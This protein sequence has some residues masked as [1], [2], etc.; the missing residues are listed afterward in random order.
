VDKNKE[1]LTAYDD[2]A[3]AIFRHCY[4][5]VLD[6]EK[7]KDLV[8]DSFIRLWKYI[9]RGEDVKN[10]KALVYKIANNLI[11]DESRKK[12]AVS[13]ELLAEKG[14]DP[15]FDYMPKLVSELDSRFIAGVLPRLEPK[16]REAVT[17][18]YVDDFSVQEIAEMTNE[19]EN[20]VSVRIH[21]GLKQL[22]EII[23]NRDG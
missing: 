1:F 22:K 7:A 4:F 5:M 13:I 14:F 17:M 2:F 10:V 15:G 3:D 9:H 21:R 6:R 18:R 11:I 16:Y 20:N 19:S 12:T 23:D 8:Q